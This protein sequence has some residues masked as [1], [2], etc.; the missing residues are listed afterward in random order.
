MS[1]LFFHPIFKDGAFT[2]N[3]REVRRF[4]LRKVMRNVDLAAELGA[5]TYV[6]WGGREGAEVDGSKDLAAAL[7]RFKEAFDIL[8]QYA[9][10][11]GYSLRFAHEPKPNEPRGDMF[12]PTIGHAMAFIET[13]EHPEIDVGP[14]KDWVVS[15]AVTHPPMFGIG[16]G[17]EQ[18]THRIGEFVDRRELRHAIAVL[19]RFPSAFAQTPR[20]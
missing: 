14:E 10:D 15:G 18:N 7:D 11:Q 4:A 20:R 17:V 8:C 6:F 13:L 12:L 3:D 16:A 19:A 1:N 5:E 2:A 9:I